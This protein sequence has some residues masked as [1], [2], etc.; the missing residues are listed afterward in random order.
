MLSEIKQFVNWVRRRNPGSRT[1]RDNGYDLKR[2]VAVVG[3][4]PPGEVTF[5][6]VDHFVNHLVSAGLV[7]Q[8]DLTDKSVE[9]NH[10]P[11]SVKLG[12]VLRKSSHAG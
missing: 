9:S 6:E 2:F 5:R 8:T 3:D 11:K 10:D 12:P 4:R 7:Q 1:W